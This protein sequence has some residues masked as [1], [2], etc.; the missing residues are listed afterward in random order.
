MRILGGVR[1][2]FFSDNYYKLLWGKRVG[3]AKIA[4]EAQ[5][6]RNS[7]VVQSKPVKRFRQN[8]G[9]KVKINFAIQM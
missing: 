9:R 2:A 7:S 8:I 6:V 4:L 5:V 3:F 1:E